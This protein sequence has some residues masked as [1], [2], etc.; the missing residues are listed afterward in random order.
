[1]IRLTYILIATAILISQ[2][3]LLEAADRFPPPDFESSYQIPQTYV[4]APAGW[5]YQYLDL[6]ILIGVL[7][8]ASYLVLKKR[9]RRW[10]FILMLFSLAYF[11]FWRRGCVC[12]IGSIQNVTLSLSD[13]EYVPSI[14]VVG[15]FILPMIFA[16][17]FGRV[18]C[19][20][21]CPLGALQDVVV[22]HPIKI[23]TWLA[24]PLGLLAYVY[25]G[26]AVLFAAT[27]SAYII[28]RYDP[29]VPIFRLSGS[30]SM[31]IL[32]ASVL[33]LGLFI[34]RP[35][36][37]FLCPY[38]A[39]LRVLSRLSKW[40]V[41]ITPDECI[42]CRLCEDSCPFG[43]I[44]KPTEYSPPPTRNQGKRR[45]AL[46]VILF[47]FLMVVGGIIGGVSGGG[48]S[49]M[50]S[51]VRLADQIRAEDADALIEPTQASTVFQ[52]TGQPAEGLYTEAHNLK[53]RFLWGGRAL[54]GFLGLVVGL[55]LIALSVRRKRIGYQAD[56]ANCL[57]CGRCF[58]YCPVE[59]R[60][61]KIMKRLI[62]DK[63]LK[64]TP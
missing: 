31:L 15:F 49:R 42:E 43:A 36:C 28:C 46:L 32:G 64:K 40:R 1:M 19:G 2:P 17:F 5:G 44:N 34:A 54:G 22:L 35:Y 21:V 57:A 12:P 59:H 3:G 7:F 9:S 30:S 14:G 26:L 4:P 24:G 62:P 18:F 60:R 20:A 10:V 45:L 8:L 61:L 39:I 51:T 48:L 58:L 6:A 23:P 55:K 53:I 56:S 11:G 63:P 13:I 27:G 16:L 29:F 41:T 38:G 37:R 47:P 33:G 52:A 50:H 25:L